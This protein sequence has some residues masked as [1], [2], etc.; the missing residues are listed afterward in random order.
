MSYIPAGSGGAGRRSFASLNGV[1]T[2][3]AGQRAKGDSIHLSTK[4]NVAPKT[5]LFKPT[6]YLYEYSTRRSAAL[7][8]SR[9]LFGSAHLRFDSLLPVL[10]H[11]PPPL[12]QVLPRSFYRSVC[13]IVAL[14][15]FGP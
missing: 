12:Y 2:G 11:T 9:L 3:W 5:D 13:P 1:N 6:L 10:G 8:R 15:L 4:L 7:C 14:C